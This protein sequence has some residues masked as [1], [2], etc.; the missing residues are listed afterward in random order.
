M[1]IYIYIYTYCPV[2]FSP[3]TGLGRPPRTCASTSRTPDVCYWLI[4]VMFR[5]VCY[6][7]AVLLLYSICLVFLLLS[8]F[9]VYVSCFTHS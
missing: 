1:Y 3:A 5:C 9:V 7:C 2:R 8:M 4:V 6:L